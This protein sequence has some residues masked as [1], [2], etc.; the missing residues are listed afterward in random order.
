MANNIPKLRF[1]EFSGEWEEKKISAIFNV[2]AGGDINPEN[3]SSIKTEVFKYP[4]FANA[5]KNKGLYGYSNIYKFESDTITIAGRGAN[6]GIVHARKE[7]F[8]PIVRLLVLLPKIKVDVYFFQDQL[9]RLNINGESTGVPQ[10]TAPQISQYKVYTTALPEQ[11]KIASF[12]SAVDKKIEQL[13]KKKELL[14]QYKK[15]M[16]QKLFTREI[17]FKDDNGKDFPEWEEVQLKDIFFEH[18]TKNVKETITE[19]FSVAK[20]K[21]VINQIEHLGRSYA[22]ENTSNY[23]VVYPNDVIYTKSPTSD[24]PFGIIKQNKTGRKG[25]VSTLY[26]VFTPKNKYIGLIMDVYFSS[27]QNTYNYLNPLVQKGAKNTMN[28]NNDDFLNGATLYVPASENEQ[29][30]IANVILQF[31]NKIALTDKELAGAKTF[32]KGL[33]QQMFV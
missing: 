3:V 20:H 33:L 31:D 24:Y 16:M 7:R 12:L 21:G 4:I 10:L 23:K 5:E 1:P 8:Y 22:A 17:R 30:K 18:K 15:G 29:V 6:I 25:I 9:N 2:K 19:V 28:I 26:G 13:Q 14:E 27:W 11:Q 32:K